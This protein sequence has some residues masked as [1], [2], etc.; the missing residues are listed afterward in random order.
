MATDLQK[1]ANRANAL[2]STGPRSLA[3]KRASSRNAMSHGLS[4]R[5]PLLQGE[6]ERHYLEL[7]GALAK[8]LQPKGTLEKLLVDD[9]AGIIWRLRRI[10][11][12]E[13]ALLQWVAHQERV[14]HD[15]DDEFAA[16][17]LDHNEP[18]DA[19][20]DFTDPLILGRTFE[21][22]LDAGLL[23]KLSRYEV[24][25]SKRLQRALQNLNAMKIA[26]AQ[27]DAGRPQP[28]EFDYLTSD[29]KIK[30]P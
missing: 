11:R 3:G 23:G 14:M 10:P 28:D 8:N 5:Y 19:I 7:H 29:G 2:R 24:D 17:P 12:L 1:A 26:R 13:M 15:G 6:S 22:M 4:A 30:P 27:L 16:P 25:L 9:V 20:E 21:T 18:N